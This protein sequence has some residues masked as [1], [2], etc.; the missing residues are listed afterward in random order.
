MGINI[1]GTNLIEVVLMRSIYIRTNL[2]FKNNYYAYSYFCSFLWTVTKLLEGTVHLNIRIIPAHTHI[3]SS[4]LSPSIFTCLTWIQLRKK[5][6]SIN[7][8]QDLSS[9][10][11]EQPT[12]VHPDLDQQPTQASQAS[13]ML[14]Q[15]QSDLKGANLVVCP[16]GFVSWFSSSL[17]CFFT[18]CTRT[19][20]LQTK[21]LLKRLMHK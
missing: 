11:L 21:T 15:E 6:A 4:S 5:N 12:R 8:T 2:L 18:M 1:C 16:G 17:Q 19:W 14:V 13:R 9:A 20:S 3:S 10:T 7:Q